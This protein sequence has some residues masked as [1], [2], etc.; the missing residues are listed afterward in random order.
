MQATNHT[1]STFHLLVPSQSLHIGCAWQSTGCYHQSTLRF[2]SLL[3]SHGS[4]F[5]CALYCCVVLEITLETQA[6]DSDSEAFCAGRDVCLYRAGTVDLELAL[7]FMRIWACK[8]ALETQAHLCKCSAGQ[9]HHVSSHILSIH[10][11]RKAQK[12]FASSSSL[13]V[14]WETLLS[15]LASRSALNT[16]ACQ[17]DFYCMPASWS[18]VSF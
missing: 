10:G 9:L 8:T 6:L 1:V 13:Q 2:Q 3:G 14:F 7:D 11:S 15:R 16:T 4:V 18:T 17:L 12:Q 5:M